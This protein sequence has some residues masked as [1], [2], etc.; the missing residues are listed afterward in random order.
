MVINIVFEDN[1]IARAARD[2][3]VYTIRDML[4][5]SK[6]DS[7]SSGDPVMAAPLVKSD[8]TLLGALSIEKMPFFNITSSSAKIFSML[9]D[10]VS[11]DIENA[12]YFQEVKKKNIL[13]EVLNIYTQDYFQ[14][15]LAQ[16]FHRAKR[17]CIPLSVVILK[18]KGLSK[19][20]VKRRLK[21]LKFSAAWLNSSLRLTD[22]VTRYKD[23]IPFSMIF[24]TTTKEQ[25]KI[26]MKRIF[27]ILDSISIGIEEEKKLVEVE[28]GVG[29]CTSTTETM[30]QMVKEA[31][32]SIGQ[33]SR[34][35]LLI[36]SL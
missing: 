9:A 5:C 28:F 20:S 21:V 31:E 25:S 33:W 2:K 8:G 17:Y 29:S 13:D 19:M 24:T 36:T 7:M 1:I 27:D 26:A 3:K 14:H 4:E 11:A 35:D 34:K 12:L 10:W 22:I 23:E 32:E 16:E 18:V 15:R 6:A 30:E